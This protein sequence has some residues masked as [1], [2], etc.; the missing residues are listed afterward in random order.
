MAW[1]KGRTRPEGAGRRKGIPNKWTKPL[2]DICTEIG[3]DPFREMVIAA[4]KITNYKEKVDACE[5]V[6]QYLHPKRKAIEHTAN[7]DPAI[8]EA[9]EA[10]SSLSVEE[11]KKIIKE[12]INE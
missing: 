8:L 3:I 2:F 5:K 9:A 7:V 11:L 12:E 10:L 4:S 1:P 6:C